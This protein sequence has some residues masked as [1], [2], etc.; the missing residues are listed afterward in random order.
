MQGISSTRN[1]RTAQSESI[2]D[3]QI[4]YRFQSGTLEG[5]SLSLQGLNLTD[6]PF[7]TF[8]DRP[9]QVITNESYGRTFLL[10]ATY[11]F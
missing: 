9:D 6:E 5:L 8:L 10:G 1:L 3:A 4:G 2:V 11:S 7:V